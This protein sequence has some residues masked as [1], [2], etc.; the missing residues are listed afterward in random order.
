MSHPA[1]TGRPLFCPPGAFSA[2][3]GDDVPHHVHDPSTQHHL[4]E[5]DDETPDRKRKGVDGTN[6]RLRPDQAWSIFP[7]GR[8]CLRRLSPSP[9]SGRTPIAPRRATRRPKIAHTGEQPYRDESGCEYRT[10]LPRDH[11]RF[12]RVRHGSSQ[13][14]SSHYQ[15]LHRTSSPVHATPSRSGTSTGEGSGE[16][17]SSHRAFQRIRRLLAR[18]MEACLPTFHPPTLIHRQI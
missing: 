16:V 13:M 15:Y 7:I 5:A 2:S 6:L 1:V 17:T 12:D 14:Y 9:N 18:R 10:V 3:T 11:G 4:T 8:W